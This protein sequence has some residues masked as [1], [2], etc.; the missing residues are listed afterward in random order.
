[1]MRGWIRTKDETTEIVKICKVC[2]SKK[3]GRCGE[4]GCFLSMLIKI[5]NYNCPLNKW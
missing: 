4:C 5:K 1:M 3:G 2:P